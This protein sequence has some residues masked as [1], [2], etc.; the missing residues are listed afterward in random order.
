MDCV[1]TRLKVGDGVFADFTRKCEGI[2][3][4]ITIENFVRRAVCDRIIAGGAIDDVGRCRIGRREGR[5][6]LDRTDHPV[7]IEILMEAGLEQFQRSAG[8]RHVADIREIVAVAVGGPDRI[9]S[10]PAIFQATS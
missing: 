8:S 10:V 2:V 7:A 6:S 9:L 4:A 3:A 5:G 1:I